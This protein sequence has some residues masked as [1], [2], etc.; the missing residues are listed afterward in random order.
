MKNE[1][2]NDHA[3]AQLQ[4][5]G[6]GIW[7][8]NWIR[9]EN[10][11]QQLGYGTALMETICREADS[12]WVSLMLYPSSTNEMSDEELTQWY[13]RFGF[14]GEHTLRRSPNAEQVL[15]ADNQQAYNRTAR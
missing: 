13:Y 10:G 2:S 14:R 1:Y 8:I 12:Q 6:G 15:T 9:T 7:I 5:Q 11:Y 4:S 3:I